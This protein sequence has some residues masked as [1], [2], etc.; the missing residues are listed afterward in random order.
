MV[1]WF[2][3]PQLISIA[4]RVGISTVFSEFADRREILATSRAIDPIKID[5]AYDYSGETM[6]GSSGSSLVADTGDGW[7]STYA[8]AR[9][10]AEPEL[11]VAGLQENL[12]RAVV[13]S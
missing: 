5:P 2:N 8:I 10:L 6:G 7:N 4:I 13:S 9:L 1:G 11:S 3:P 12:Y